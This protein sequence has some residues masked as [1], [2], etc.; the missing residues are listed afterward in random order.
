MS[1]VKVFSLLELRRRDTSRLRRYFRCTRTHAAHERS[2][3]LNVRR[4]PA[5]PAPESRH[6]PGTAESVSSAGGSNDGGQNPGTP[7]SL[8]QSR[9]WSA[10]R[11]SN[12]LLGRPR[13]H[14]SE[15]ESSSMTSPP[16]PSRTSGSRSPCHARAGGIS[17][18]DS[19]SS[20]SNLPGTATLA[21]GSISSQARTV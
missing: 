18:R 19:T 10:I 9:C 12:R 11:R 17:F 3:S 14:L 2:W 4:S 13:S 8:K 6:L 16:S 20:S 21:S 15:W 1:I 5:T 7:G